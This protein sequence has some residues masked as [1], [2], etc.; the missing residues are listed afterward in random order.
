MILKCY[1]RNYMKLLDL[2]KHFK[3]DGVHEK[4]R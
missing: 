2:L 1:K 3:N 4:F